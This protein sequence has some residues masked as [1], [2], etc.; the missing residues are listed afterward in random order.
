MLMRAGLQSLSQL[1]GDLD[2]KRRGGLPCSERLD[3]HRL[4]M[5]WLLEDGLWEDVKRGLLL[6]RK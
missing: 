4:G 5:L 2:G 3:L 1:P 6:A